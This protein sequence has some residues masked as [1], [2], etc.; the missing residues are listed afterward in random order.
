MSKD[1]GKPLHIG[2]IWDLNESMG[3]CCGYP[4]AGYENQGISNGTSGGSAIS[5]EGF[6]FNIC[7]EPRRCVEDP[8]DGISLWF[9]AVWRRVRVHFI[10]FLQHLVCEL[11]YSFADGGS[12]VWHLCILISLAQ[13]MCVLASAPT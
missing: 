11:L 3:M 6:R 1:K 9:R 10:L 8:V 7:D 2:P 12:F 5:P 13:G 4:I